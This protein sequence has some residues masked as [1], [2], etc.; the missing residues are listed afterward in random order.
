MEIEHVTNAE[1]A[2][3]TNYWK[4]KKTKTKQ[5][6]NQKKKRS[7]N[8]LKNKNASGWITKENIALYMYLLV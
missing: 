1:T 6:K 8:A 5:N 2:I 7:K 3:G 4:N